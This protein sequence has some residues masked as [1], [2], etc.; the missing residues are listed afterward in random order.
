[1]KKTRKVV[2]N[3]VKHLLACGDIEKALK[4][5]DEEIWNDFIAWIRNGYSDSETLIIVKNNFL[6]EW[7]EIASR[8]LV[9]SFA[10]QD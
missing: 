10:R 1:M 8:A 6:V 9:D 3:Y 4:M 2:E 7:K 5:S